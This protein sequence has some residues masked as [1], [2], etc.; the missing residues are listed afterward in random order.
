MNNKIFESSS[1]QA[2]A[3]QVVR[4][5]RNITFEV[6]RYAYGSTLNKHGDPEVID[7]AEQHTATVVDPEPGKVLQHSCGSVV[8]WRHKFEF[9]NYVILE[10]ECGYI[11]AR[12]DVT[13]PAQEHGR[14]EMRAV[15]LEGAKSVPAWEV[16]RQTPE[17]AWFPVEGQHLRERI[18]PAEQWIQ[19]IKTTILPNLVACHDEV[20]SRY[21]QTTKSA[22][23]V[24]HPSTQPLNYAEAFS[25]AR[26]AILGI[27]HDKLD[28]KAHSAKNDCDS[29]QT[30]LERHRENDL[31]RG[32]SR[33]LPWVAVPH[34]TKTLRLQSSLENAVEHYLK[35]CDAVSEFQN[36]VDASQ[37]HEAIDHRAKQLLA[38]QELR[39]QAAYASRQVAEA[40][41]LVEC[42]QQHPKE[43]VTLLQTCIQGR[44]RLSV[45]KPLSTEYYSKELRNSCKVRL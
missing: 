15:T 41:E 33:F 4:K 17:G 30:A 25:L 29:A 23:V 16:H 27:E 45:P 39:C 20:M 6:C 1:K 14:F 22:P 38:A 10:H 5:P 3:E 28:A 7:V 2:E 42:L 35:T 43:M 44:Q 31:R 26:K 36:R 37:L 24:C 18:L 13:L 21:Q 32:L 12:T 19:E 11:A 9:Q 34:F 8:W 40:E